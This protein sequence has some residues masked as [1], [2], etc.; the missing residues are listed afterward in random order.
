MGAGGGGGGAPLRFP[1]GL[2]CLAS[3]IAAYQ[4]LTERL[5]RA[6]RGAGGSRPGGRPGGLWVLVAPRGRAA[7]WF[8]VDVPFFL[9]S[10]ISVSF[11]SQS[12]SFS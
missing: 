5:W 8:C 11:V 12:V 9:F 10:L 4:I 7:R 6:G 2:V 3:S 1:A